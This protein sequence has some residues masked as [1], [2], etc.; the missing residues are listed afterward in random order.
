MK[1]LLR[2]LIENVGMEY[3]QTDNRNENPHESSNNNGVRVILFPNIKLK[4]SRAQYYDIEI[5]INKLLCLLTIRLFASQEVGDG[6]Q[7]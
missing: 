4:L 6:I 7:V 2:D 1:I 3:I 5:F